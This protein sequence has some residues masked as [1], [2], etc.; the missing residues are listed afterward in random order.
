M[1]ILNSAMRAGAEET[2]QMLLMS[3]NFRKV[4][5]MTPARQECLVVLNPDRGV[6]QIL[7]RYILISDAF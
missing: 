6:V 7:A 3:L 5:N 4:C 1:A 2:G